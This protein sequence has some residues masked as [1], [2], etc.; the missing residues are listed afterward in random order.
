MLPDG[1]LYEWQVGTGSQGVELG[2]TL[3]ASLSSEYYDDLRL[4]TDPDT[5]AAT[6]IVSANSVVKQVVFGNHKLF[7]KARLH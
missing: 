4:L 3:I 1:S 6:V 5:A 7:K 2:G